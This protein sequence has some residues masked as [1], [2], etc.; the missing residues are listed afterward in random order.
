MPMKKAKGKNRKQFLTKVTAGML[1]LLITGGITCAPV[2]AAP[3]TVQVIVN[4]S[5]MQ[6]DQPAVI[7]NGR[8]MVPFN[9]IFSM[10][11]ASVTWNEPE[12]KVTGT[13]DLTVIELFIGKNVAKV[14]GIPIQM[15]VPVQIINGRT[16]VPLSF[17]SSNLGAQVQW[18]GVNYIASVTTGQ[19][20]V[21]EGLFGELTE[22]VLPAADIPAPQIPSQEPAQVP[23]VQVPPADPSTKTNVLVGNFAAQ[24]LK[25]QNFAIQFSNTMTVDM[26]HLNAKKEEKGIYSVNGDVVTIT[27][28]MIN[29]NFKM[30]N[31]K[32]NG[33]E[34]ILLRDPSN[35]K[36]A[37]AMTPIPYEEFTKI[38][39][40]EKAN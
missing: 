29:G 18:D 38:W 7:R 39:A 30:E 12:Q 20:S 15:D 28:S 34:I 4:G 13:R 10:L 27:S 22:P 3:E 32:Y 17:V 16:M 9:A 5:V 26:K 40:G 25:K 21:I 11:G 2:S 36:N 14:N 6:S 37:V 23:A 1:A 8:T 24:N 31:L 33:R 19:T 35:A